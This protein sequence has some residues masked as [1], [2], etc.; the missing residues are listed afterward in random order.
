M[1]LRTLRYFLTLAR[2]ENISRAAEA[3]YITQPTLSRQLGDL[4]K[5]L[6]VR[7][8][9]RGKRKIT[10]TPEGMLLRRRAEEMI[11]LENKVEAEFRC[12]NEEISGVVSIGAAETAA[13][14][15]L[16]KAITSFREKYPGVTFDIHSDIATHVKERLDRGVLDLGLLVE[17]GDID[18][19]DFLRLGINDRCG[20]L[21][22]VHSP[23]AQR[24]YV[25]IEDL[26]GLPVI[27]NKRAEVQSFYRIA[28][29]DT[30]DRLNKIATFNLIN[31]A[32]LFAK[33]DLGYVFTIEGVVSHFK[34][35]EV[36]FRPFKPEISQ[37][38]FIIWKK[39]QPQSPVVSKFIDEVAMLLG[40]KSQ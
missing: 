40:H 23:L 36:C 15:I 16:P 30:Y 9:E 18:K 14:E 17:P 25:E 33:H 4:E 6:G 38:T 3:L 39:Y 8:F 29:G 37:S 35:D 12:H 32:A 34:A 5:E 26:L 24:E 31:N 20:I 7:L 19:Y 28:L 22:N 2:E 21:M 1:E 10:L 11:E 27:C 13:A